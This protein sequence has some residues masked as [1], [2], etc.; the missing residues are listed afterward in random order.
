M[1]VGLLSRKDSSINDMNILEMG[2]YPKF[3][4]HVRFWFSD[5]MGSV[6]V[7]S[8]LK[9]GSGSVRVL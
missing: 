9:T 4:V 2:K 3:W 7:L 6:R 8:T 5:D 1:F